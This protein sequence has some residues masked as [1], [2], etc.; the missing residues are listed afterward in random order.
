MDDVLA[1]LRDH[2]TETVGHPGGTLYTHLRRVHDR[3][4]VLGHDRWVQLAGLT[5]AAYSTDGF[6]LAL[7]DHRDRG[8]LRDLI[9]NQAEDLVHRYGSCDRSRTWIALPQTRQVRN[10]W[11]DRSD[12]LPADVATAFADLSIINELDVLDHD[13]SIAARYSTYFRDLFTSWEG[14]ASPAAVAEVRRA[15]G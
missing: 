10:R 2:G 7:T 12:P 4:G 13:A 11:S 14:L 9:G 3:L 6:D 8:P 5:H 1:W 15:L